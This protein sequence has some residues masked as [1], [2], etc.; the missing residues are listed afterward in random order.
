M[1]WYYFEIDIVYNSDLKFRHWG[2]KEGIIESL[3]IFKASD[4]LDDAGV[5]LWI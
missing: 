2:G 1:N 5:V 4:I 3:S